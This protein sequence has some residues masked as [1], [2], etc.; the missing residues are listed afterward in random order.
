MHD[1][2]GLASGNFM[3]R[4]FGVVS[5]CMAEMDGDTSKRLPVL[6]VA[7]ISFDVTQNRCAKELC[8]LPHPGRQSTKIVDAGRRPNNGNQAFLV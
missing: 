3:R 8:I 1:P 5:W 6:A 4:V 7:E 2:G